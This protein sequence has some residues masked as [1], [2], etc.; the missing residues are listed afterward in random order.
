MAA[1]SKDFLEV[2]DDIPSARQQRSRSS[3]HVDRIEELER[4]ERRERE[5]KMKKYYD[6]TRYSS[7]LHQR[8]RSDHLSVPI[9][10]TNRRPRSSER[11]EQRR[12]ETPRDYR[13]EEVRPGP[14]PYKY[15]LKTEPVLPSQL[16]VPIRG[17]SSQPERPTVKVPPVIIQENPPSPK[18]TS[19]RNLKRS[20]GASPHSPTA[21]PELQFQ[22]DTLQSKLTQICN[23]CVPYLEVEPANPQDLTFAK[24]RETI[25]GFAEDLH[26]WSHIANLD[27]LARIDKNM[28][29]LVDAASDTLHRLLERATE[30]REACA[31]AKPKDLKMQPLDGIDDDDDDDDDDDFE[32]YD[33]GD[34]AVSV[35]DPT[36]APGFVIH[37]LLHSI[38]MQIRHLKLLSPSLQEATPD[39]QDEMVNVTRLVKEAGKFFGSDA[40]LRQYSI[41]PKFAGHKAFVEARYSA[42]VV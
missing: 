24:I 21:Q 6:N 13:V 28:R 1:I 19:G 11:T 14:Q 20:P 42:G 23:S 37:S 29:H 3:G 4:L 31:T 16:P 15:D 41:D 22:Y 36:E 30:L 40:A 10:E 38:G 9:W 7:I 5:Q 39:L 8:T 33:D 18:K 32:L 35:E 17:R 12:E 25:E 2:G 34:G 27:G 26:I